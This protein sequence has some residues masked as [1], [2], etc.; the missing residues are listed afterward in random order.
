VVKEMKNTDD[1]FDKAIEFLE[2][3]YKESLKDAVTEIEKEHLTNSF[4]TKIQEITEREKKLAN[5]RRS[6][7]KED[8]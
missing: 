7:K 2:I 3:R 5:I 4:G 8:V 1:N 6:I